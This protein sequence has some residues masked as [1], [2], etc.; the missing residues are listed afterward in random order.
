MS[1]TWLAVALVCA[2]FSSRRVPQVAGGNAPPRL[3][4]ELGIADT[5]LLDQ[6]YLRSNGEFVWARTRVAVTEDEGSARCGHPV[7]MRTR[8]PLRRRDLDDRSGLAVAHRPGALL[9]ARSAAG[10][11]GRSA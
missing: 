5:Y 10:C 9:P 11:R 7:E 1:R 4:P 3:L 8:G 6:R 2:F